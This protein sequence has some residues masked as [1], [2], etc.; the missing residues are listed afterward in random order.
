LLLMLSSI[1]TSVLRASINQVQLL[2][3]EAAN[4]F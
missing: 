3:L 2:N 4:G 1:L